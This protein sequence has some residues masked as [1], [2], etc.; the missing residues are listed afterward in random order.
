MDANFQPVIQ[1]Y[2]GVEKWLESLA[3]KGLSNTEV[4]KIG[5]GNAVRMI[6]A[7]LKG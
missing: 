5:G 1:D 3:A 2:F 7:V 4:E 6:G